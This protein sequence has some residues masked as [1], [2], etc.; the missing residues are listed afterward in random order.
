MRTLGVD[1]EQLIC[2]I[3]P[4]RNHLTEQLHEASVAWAQRFGLAPDERAYQKIARIHVA[5]L[6]A[7]TY[8][9]A[10]P[11]LLRLLTDMLI[12][13]F[14]S[15]DQYDERAIGAAPH[16]L[17]K[18]CNNFMRIV[19]TGNQKLAISPL[20]RSLLDIRS[21][22]AS[23]GDPEWFGRFTK[24]MEIYFQ[25]CLLESHNRA[26]Q[27]TPDFD[28][29][30]QIRRASVGTYPCFDLIELG[31]PAR[32]SAADAAHPAIT[33]LRDLATDII[34]W[35]N[36]IV[37]FQKEDAY[38]DP[39]NIVAVLTSECGISPEAAAQKTVEIH[40]EEMADFR[41][42]SAAYL[43]KE[44]RPLL[45]AYVAGLESWIRGVLD[46]SFVSLRYKKEYLDLSQSA[47]HILVQE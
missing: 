16:K 17:E 25:G 28:D 46:W 13:F 31:L 26:E 21:R 39:H 34:S 12:W 40:N 4:R 47:S 8:P 11:E 36:D 15:D 23:Y 2:P 33:T 1:P 38:S 18:I 3:K 14:V 19:E 5:S 22:I 20:G 27:I 35:V 41:Q 24:S 6:S 32:L 30:K 7:W 9:D 37:S 10:E 45:A 42:I 44:R 29:Y 43:Q